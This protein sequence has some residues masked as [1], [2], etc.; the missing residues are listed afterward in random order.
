MQLLAKYERKDVYDFSLQRSLQKKKRQP[1][2]ITQDL[3]SYHTYM[4]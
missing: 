3:L 1:K 2:S 4:Q